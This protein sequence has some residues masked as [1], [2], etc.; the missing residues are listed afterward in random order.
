MLISTLTVPTRNRSFPRKS[1][2]NVHYK[3]VYY[4]VIQ[5]RATKGWETK[6][7]AWLFFMDGN[8]KNDRVGCSLSLYFLPVC[9]SVKVA[10]K[11]P[12][13]REVAPLK[14]TYIYKNI[15]PSFSYA[16]MNN[17]AFFPPSLSLGGKYRSHNVWPA[18]PPNQVVWRLCD[19]RVASSSPTVRCQSCPRAG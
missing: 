19:L 18:S 11:R 16:M 9:A 17:G 8:K 3:Q 10:E 1:H 6:K 5:H 15:G 14:D 2:G 13:I 4:K 12:K 7:Y